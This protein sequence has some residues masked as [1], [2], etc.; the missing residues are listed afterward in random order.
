MLQYS[1]KFFPTCILCSSLGFWI[2]TNF[3]VWATSGLYSKTLTGLGECYI[4]ALPF[5]LNS[6]I[7]DMIWGLAILGVY[8][9]HSGWLKTPLRRSKI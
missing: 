1:R 2:W 9:L 6:L 3:G 7:G 5:L 8:S 4:A